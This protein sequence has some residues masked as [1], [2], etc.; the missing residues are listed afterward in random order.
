[1]KNLF[2]KEQEKQICSDYFSE[3]KPSTA[4]LAKKYNCDG[5]TIQNV[6]RRSGYV[7]RNLSESHIGQKSWSKG[8]TKETNKGLQKISKSLEG[9]KIPEEIKRKRCIFTKEEEH[10]ICKEYFSKESPS[11]TV[12]GEKW[13]CNHATIRNIIIKNGYKL[14]TYSDSHKGEKTKQKMHDS[15]LGQKSWSIGL[16]KET[17]E[18]IKRASEK[19]KGQKRSEEEKQKMREK[20]LSRTNLGPFKDTK[21][22]LKMKEILTSLNIPFGH[23]FRLGNHLYDFHILNTNILIEVDGDYWHSNPKKFIK[24]NKIQKETKQRDIKNEQLA[25][26]KGFILLRFWEDDI[27]NNAKEVKNILQERISNAYL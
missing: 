11:I 1:M 19:K 22:E 9:R 2:T 26:D 6:I 25:K 20:A 3:R 7:L 17:D 8:F 4:T 15:H 14:R 5:A 27:L 16:T 13:K 12:L 21:P 10:Q 18:R 23:Q 24:L